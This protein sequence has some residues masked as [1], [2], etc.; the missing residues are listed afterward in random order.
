MFGFS[1]LM[2][3]FWSDVWFLVE[4]VSGLEYIVIGYASHTHTHPFQFHAQVQQKFNMTAY[5][6]PSAVLQ[7]VV[8][9]TKAIMERELKAFCKACLDELQGKSLSSSG[10]LGDNSSSASMAAAS[11]KQ[12]MSTATHVVDA[13]LFS[14][15]IIDKE[16]KEKH[17][18]GETL[19]TK[20][21]RS[22]IMHTSTFVRDVLFAKTTNNGYP[23]IRQPLQHPAPF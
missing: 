17:D 15:G 6:T 7:G 21:C 23:Q 11:N 22:T 14:L 19:T 10:I 12:C 3:G 13:G 16:Q 8:T 4:S 20:S 1:G 5:S 9:S 18:Q 2:F